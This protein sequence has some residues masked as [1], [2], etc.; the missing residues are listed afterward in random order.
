MI[1]EDGRLYT[2]AD[3]LGGKYQDSRVNAFLSAQT[4]NG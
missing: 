2:S 4:Q 1:G 3:I